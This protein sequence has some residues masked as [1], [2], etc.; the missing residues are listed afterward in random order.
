MGHTLSPLP[1]LFPFPTPPPSHPFAAFHP[2]L[3]IEYE[4]PVARDQECLFRTQLYLLKIEF[5]VARE[6]A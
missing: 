3:D 1:T 6:G 4:G 5:S 2:A